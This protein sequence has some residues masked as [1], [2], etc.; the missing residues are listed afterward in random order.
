MRVRITAAELKRCGVSVPKGKRAATEL[1]E[2]KM[3]YD[4][5]CW[6][7]TMP[8]E[9]ASEINLRDWR[10]RSK[11]SDVAWRAVS[12]ML[13]A[14]LDF[15]SIFSGKY[16]GTRERAVGKGRQTEPRPI[17][18]RF[19]RIGGKRLD[20]S[21]LPTA[22]KAVEDAVAFIMGADDGDP[23]WCAKWEQE[24]GPAVGVRVELDLN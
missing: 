9:T 1:V 20:P 2:P 8:I 7:F 6:K 22:L 16:H 3:E 21:N 5:F 17:K 10:K 24:P 14:H 19:I 15:V 4:C 23:R 11:R 18:L 13:G 12:K